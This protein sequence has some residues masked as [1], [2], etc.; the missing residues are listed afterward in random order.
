[1]RQHIVSKEK[2]IFEQ[3]SEIPKMKSPVEEGMHKVS[4]GG[5]VLETGRKWESVT[6]SVQREGRFTKK[7]AFSSGDWY[8]GSCKW[9]VENI[10]SFQT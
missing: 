7:R 1:M 5:L 4:W 10:T 2:S 8:W 9:R 3:P 6:S